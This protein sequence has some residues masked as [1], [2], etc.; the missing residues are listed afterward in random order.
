MFDKT[1]VPQLVIV[2]FFA[3]LTVPVDT[4]PNTKFVVLKQTLG[5]GATPMPLS[6][7]MRGLPV[8]SSLMTSWA[9][10]SPPAVGV[11]A[12]LMEQFCPGPMPPVQPC[13]SM[14]KSV[15]FVGSKLTPETPI[16]TVVLFW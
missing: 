2:T 5:S 3:T 13:D 1:A 9:V 12:I 11:K 6:G 7:T 4:L 16:L 14:T 15:V 10:R 8:A